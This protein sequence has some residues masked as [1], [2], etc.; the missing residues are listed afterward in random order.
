MTQNVR[1]SLEVLAN[2]TRHGAE[3]GSGLFRGYCSPSLC[4]AE[5]EIKLEQWI[6]G[7]VALPSSPTPKLLTWCDY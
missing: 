4:S 7:T 6:D 1:K 3:L 5:I 2:L